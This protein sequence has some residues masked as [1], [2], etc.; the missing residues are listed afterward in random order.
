MSLQFGKQDA[1]NDG[2]SK[3]HLSDEELSELGHTRES[4]IDHIETTYTPDIYNPH[5]LSDQTE[6]FHGLLDGARD[7]RRR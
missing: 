6:F 3:G 1:Y 4:F 5:I 2:Y 7:L